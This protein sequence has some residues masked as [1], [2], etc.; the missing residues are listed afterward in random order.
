MSG[1]SEIIS[2]KVSA[3]RSIVCISD[4]FNPATGF[5]FWTDACQRGSGLSHK[6]KTPRLFVLASLGSCGLGVASTGIILYW[7]RIIV[8]AVFN[9]I[10]EDV[11]SC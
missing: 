10:S 3:T 5:F 6:K 4:D 11:V 8:A 9:A 2:V 7:K 1:R